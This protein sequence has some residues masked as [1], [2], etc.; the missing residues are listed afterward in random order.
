MIENTE[1]GSSAAGQQRAGTTV[2]EH[3]AEVAKGA[4]E[5]G[6]HVAQT[7]VDQGK[8]VAKET[9]RQAR[10]LIGEVQTQLKDQT[11]TGQHKA[12]NGLRN[13]GNELR[14]MAEHADQQSMASD[15]I[16]QVSGR[17]NQ[18]ADWLDQREPGQL[19]DEV[20]QF[21][22]RHPGAFLVGAA[23]AGALAGRLTRN[24]TSAAS[25]TEDRQPAA[26]ITGGQ[27]SAGGAG[28]SQ[29][30]IGNEETVYG[31]APMPSGSI[32]SEVLP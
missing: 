3:S 28:V 14:S 7:A 32:P 2:K 11:G 20:R 17:M 16:G 18:V 10:N 23:A 8:Q 19:L 5:A 29:P 25:G 1:Y 24:I 12:A 15:V 21:A 26:G 4:T 27:P 13:M 30:P 6:G 31:S 22:R 9:G